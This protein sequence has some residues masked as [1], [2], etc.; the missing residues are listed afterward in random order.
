MQPISTLI[1]VPGTQQEPTVPTI[2]LDNHTNG[3]VGSTSSGSGHGV[4][5][6]ALARTSLSG[7]NYHHQKGNINQH[8]HYNAHNPTSGL[9]RFPSI[10]NTKKLTIENTALKAKVVE[11]ERYLTGLKEELILANRQI[12][13]QRQELKTAEERKVELSELSLNWGLRFWNAMT[14][15]RNWDRARNLNRS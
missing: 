7:G 12:H 8:H 14:S 4:A 6:P 1:L 2:P 15:R 3:S 9:R 5:A 13:A 10:G 11:L